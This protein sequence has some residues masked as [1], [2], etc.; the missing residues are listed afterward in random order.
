MEFMGLVFH[1][2]MK[3]L[4][5]EYDAASSGTFRCQSCHGDDMEARRFAMPATLRPV[6][7]EAR[8]DAGAREPRVTE[9][10]LSKVLPA[11][12]ELLSDTGDG[13]TSRIGCDVCHSK[14]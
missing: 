3:E 8:G 5:Q 7:G 14:Q 4:F 13:A 1:P 10:M 9:F 12:R 6:S 2:R 11:T